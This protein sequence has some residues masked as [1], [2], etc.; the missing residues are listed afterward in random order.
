MENWNISR[1]VLGSSLVAAGVAGAAWRASA[2]APKPAAPPPTPPAEPLPAGALPKTTPEAAAAQSSGERVLCYVGGYTKHGPPE[3]NAKGVTLFE[4]NPDNGVLTHLSVFEDTDN[5]SFLALSHDRR[6]LY[7]CNELE[8]YGANKDSGAATAFSIDPHTGVLTKLN[9]VTSAGA[10]PAH[11]SVHPSG[12]FLLVANYSSGSVA[13][14]RIKDD[15]SL[16]ERT[17]LVK[18]SGPRMPERAKDNP[19]GNYAVSD[20]SGAHAHMV[21]ADVAGRFVLVADA[22]LDRIYVFTL[23]PDHGTLT[24]AKIPFHAM[25]PGSAPRHFC[26]SP[27]GKTIY[28]LG[29]QNSRVVVADYDTDTGA[30]SPRQSISTVT[31]HFRGSTIAAGIM[32]HPNGKFLYV[33]NRLGNSIAVFGVKPDRSLALLDEVWARADYGRSLSFDP[34]AKFLFVANQRSDSITSF[35]VDPTTGALDFTW[36]F[37]PVGTPTAFAFT[38]TKA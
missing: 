21:Q 20:H 32:L 25:E 11:L 33:T 37:T 10:N 4:M 14:I 5:P 13:V 19:P 12:R 26:F 27:D 23:D 1:R 29:E 22:G 30:I 6:F 17:A 24:P 15:G 7:A 36:T 8:D 34:A 18:N 9:T 3:A 16:G 31:S 28:I 35:K 38:T 2:A